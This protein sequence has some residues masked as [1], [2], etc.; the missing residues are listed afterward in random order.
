MHSLDLPEDFVSADFRNFQKNLTKIENL[1]FFSFG[2][3]HL[4]RL[5]SARSGRHRR[6][7]DGRL[8]LREQLLKPD[9]IFR[10]FV[11]RTSNYLKFFKILYLFI[12]SI[13]PKS[14]CYHADDSKSKF[15]QNFPEFFSILVFTS[16]KSTKI[17]I[18][19]FYHDAI[20]KFS[21]N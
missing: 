14:P 19:F 4:W 5:H 10:F 13:S 12:V 11:E 9:S 7:K 3:R 17:K 6:W 18:P 1:F 16:E 15:F 21:H 2:C 8:P 20:N